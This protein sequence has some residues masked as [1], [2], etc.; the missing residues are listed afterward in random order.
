MI[1]LICFLLNWH[2][3]QTMDQF[4]NL[5]QKSSPCN[6]Q[7]IAKRKQELGCNICR[8]NVI[9]NAFT[10]NIIISSFFLCND[11]LVPF[12]MNCKFTWFLVWWGYV[13][14]FP[15]LWCDLQRPSLLHIGATS[16]H[17]LALYHW[18]RQIWQAHIYLHWGLEILVIGPCTLI[19]GI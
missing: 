12:Y 17:A 4:H 6:A 11:T 14:L 13:I 10:C 16:L 15:I 18:L 7:R 8:F 1:F 19:F 9:I 2:R 3:R 5:I